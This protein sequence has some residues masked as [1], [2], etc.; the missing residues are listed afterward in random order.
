MG[1]AA[2]EL[3][4]A[5]VNHTSD[6]TTSAGILEGLWA[7][8]HETLGD[9]TYP[10]KYVRDQNAPRVLCWFTVRGANGK[11]SYTDLGRNRTCV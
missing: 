6:P 7:L 9:I 2:A 8:D 11:W 4:Q 1:W 10:I 5:A 3:F